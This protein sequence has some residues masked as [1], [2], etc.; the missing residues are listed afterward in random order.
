MISHNVL[1]QPSQ[2]QR[3]PL[4][5]IT[6]ICMSHLRKK[7]A[8]KNTDRNKSIQLC[9]LK[10]FVTSSDD[11]NALTDRQNFGALI[12]G[13]RCNLQGAVDKAWLIK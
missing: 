6:N 4:Y 9:R 5:H 1:R 10:K 2:C 3:Q 7:V 13:K 12:E 11:K 8:Q